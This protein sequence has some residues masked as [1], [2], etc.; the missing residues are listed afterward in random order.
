MFIARF[1]AFAPCV[2]VAVESASAQSLISSRTNY[3]ALDDVEITPDQHYA[4]V[5]QNSTLGFALVFDLTTGLQ[6]ASIA[7]NGQFCGDL[8]DGVAVTNTRAVVMGG[9]E[10]AILDLTQVGTPG[11]LLALQPAGYRPHDVTITPNGNFAIV[12]GGSSAVG[13]QYIYDLT[14][15]ALVASA[16]GEPPL[17][18][19]FGTQDY[20]YATDTV[21]A[22]NTHA[23]VTSILGQSST[24]PSTHVTIWRLTGGTPSIALQST[25][26]GA[27]HDV[28]ISPDGQ[29][30][31]VRSELSVAAFSL[32]ST[33][34]LAWNLPPAPSTWL[35]EDRA[36]DS[37][38]VTNDAVITI[39]RPAF[40]S[41]TVGTQVD[42]FE[43]NGTQRHGQ[44]AGSPHDLAVTPDGG[45]AIVRTQ[46][47]VYSY[48][49]NFLLPGPSVSPIESALTPSSTIGYEEGLDSVAVNDHFAVTL[50]HTTDLASTDVWFWSIERARLRFISKTRILDSRPTDVM[51]TA[52]GT[53]A[54]VTGTASI[55]VFHLATGGLVFEHH[56]V[57]SNAFYQWCD[58]VAASND[59][60]VGI[61]QWGPQNGWIDV[62]DTSAFHQN[63]CV[64]NPNS[65]GRAAEIRALGKKSVASNALKLTVENV[66]AG[67]L[68][69]FVYGA[70]QTQIPF[71]DG[72]QCIAAPAHGLR[73][74]NANIVGAALY[75]V[76]FTALVSPQG[77]IT[78]GSTWNFQFIYTD[79]NS[80]AF[81]VNSSNALSITFTP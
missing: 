33:P 50:T 72:V 15:G 62:V 52:D 3:L 37:V 60:A 29:H 41:A 59:R 27:P 47:G 16:L 58:G 34:S 45:R 2:L 19:Y 46:T 81:G 32:T 17:Y 76:D 65:T 43:W 42:V 24:S 21:A 66:P 64:A 18:D 79:P 57:G 10:I 53:R 23:V 44:I 31:V 56:A 25:L 6:V 39:S 14:S 4:V 38:E 68:G 75:P 70:N 49:L 40:P 78:A 63:Y 13:G 55:S 28:A 1:F 5:R 71:G 20:S 54:I 67:A 73:F 77:V 80:A 36:L 9:D 74:Q 69:R 26:V 22:T 7:G 51:I 30:A 11:V 35:F 8:V 61:G 48:A 12:R